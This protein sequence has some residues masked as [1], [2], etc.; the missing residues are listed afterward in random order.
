MVKRRM[1]PA[2]PIRPRFARHRRRAAERRCS[3]RRSLPDAPKAS[4]FPNLDRLWVRD[5]T[6]SITARTR[7]VGRQRLAK[8]YWSHRYFLTGSVAAWALHDA[9]QKV[10]PKAGRDWPVH[11]AKHLHGFSQ[12]IVA[13]VTSSARARQRTNTAGRRCLER[14]DGGARPDARATATT[15][16]TTPPPAPATAVHNADQSWPLTLADYLSSYW[17]SFG[18]FNQKGATLRSIRKF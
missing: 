3:W 9:G 15:G 4:P 12:R 16:D 8:P 1:T 18:K 7:L 5:F 6:S 10:A 13:T 17:I 14:R 2:A 11:G